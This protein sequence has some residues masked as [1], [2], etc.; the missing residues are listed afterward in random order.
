MRNFLI[1]LLLA[2][3]VFPAMASPPPVD[4]FDHPEISIHFSD[5]VEPYCQFVS[6]EFDFTAVELT[7]SDT[8]SAFP[9]HCHI[10]DSLLA[11]ALGDDPPDQF[12]LRPP[13]T[14]YINEVPTLANAILIPR[15]KQKEQV[16]NYHRIQNLEMLHSTVNP[17]NNLP[18]Q[19]PIQPVQ[20]E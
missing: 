10:A 6:V 8:P 14:H 4:D 5:G 18:N 12:N 11:F 2:F 7:A 15:Y 13:S 16:D 1:S 19:L 3:L 20:L 17:P 9:Y